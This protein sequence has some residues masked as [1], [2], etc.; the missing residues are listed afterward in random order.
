LSTVKNLGNFLLLVPL[1]V[2]A[3]DDETELGLQACC[4]HHVLVLAKKP[5]LAFV[6]A[7]HQLTDIKGTGELVKKPAFN[8]PIS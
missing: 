2:P 3:I 8:S 5:S 7:S 4:R 6:P 1:A